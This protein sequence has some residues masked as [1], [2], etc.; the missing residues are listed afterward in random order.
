MKIVSEQLY[1]FVDNLQNFNRNEF[2]LYV[3]LLLDELTEGFLNSYINFREFKQMED[4]TKVLSTYILWLYDNKTVLDK[5]Q[6]EELR[7]IID[8]WQECINATIQNL[9][10][11][12]YEKWAK[13]IS[14]IMEEEKEKEAAEKQKDQ[15][16][17]SNPGG[18]G[19]DE[20]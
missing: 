12:E 2:E 7:Q 20:G 11:S 10:M 9:K 14:A 1:S 4:Y 3:S 17:T 18:Y 8:G 13:K 15:P 5:S 19:E 16:N 6:Q